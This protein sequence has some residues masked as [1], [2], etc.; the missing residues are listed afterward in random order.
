[1]SNVKTEVFTRGPG[2]SITL[3]EN[4]P[5]INSNRYWKSY[6]VQLWPCSDLRVSTGENEV[7]SDDID[8][9]GD[10]RLRSF[11]LSFRRMR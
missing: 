1:M 9:V 3:R 4:M 6:G 10:N 11:D 2:I 5:R 8:E 7:W